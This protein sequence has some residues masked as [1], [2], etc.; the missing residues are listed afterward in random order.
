MVKRSTLITVLLVILIFS[1][2]TSGYG[3]SYRR[4]ITAWFNNIQVE[5]DGEKLEMA[6]EP[7]IFDN[8]VYMP[9]EELADALYLNLVYDEKE[10]K[11]RINTNRIFEVDPDTSSVPVTFQKHYELES[12]KNQVSELRGIVN[13][14]Q[15]G[16]IEYKEIKTVAEMEKYIKEHFKELGTLTMD[17]EFKELSKDSYLLEASFGHDIRKWED[18]DRRT[19]ENWVD[20][21]FYAVRLLFN[22]NAVIEGSIKDRSITTG[23]RHASYYTRGKLLYFDFKLAEHKENQ[24]VDGARIERALKDRLSTYYHENFKYEVFVNRK[25]VD[26]VISLDGNNFNNWSTQM[27]MLY[28]KRIKTEIYRID[29][30]VNI[31]GRIINSRNNDIL[32]RFSIQDDVIRSADLLTDIE[33]DLKKNYSRLYYDKYLFNLNINVYEGYSGAFEVIVEIDVTKDDASL[34]LLKD[35]GEYILRNHLNGA[36]KYIEGIYDVDIYGEIVDKNLDFI[37]D[38]EFYRPSAGHARSLQPIIFP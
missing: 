11:V 14:L 19:I 26:V 16:R 9:M 7:L 10:S 5:V 4:T 1:F 25:D 21:V 2:T 20:D 17:I 28:L 34:K 36:F 33:N 32:L 24:L 27:K 37:C 3:Q 30:T 38:L 15:G 6:N 8:K 12:L 31:N 23:T 29:D 13:R 35:K 22:S 18:L